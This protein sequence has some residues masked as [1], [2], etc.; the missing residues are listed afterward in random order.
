MWR[1][2]RNGNVS[3]KSEKLQSKKVWSRWNYNSDRSPK[4][5]AKIEGLVQVYCWII[6]HSEI[7]TIIF[8]RNKIG[9][10]VADQVQTDFRKRIKHVQCRIERKLVLALIA[11]Q[12]FTFPSILNHVNNSAIFLIKTLTITKPGWNIYPMFGLY[13]TSE[14]IKGNTIGTPCTPYNIV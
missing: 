3:G 13:C 4:E 6:I 9:I 8:F 5:L 14:I 12:I 10:H 11:F 1:P 7:Q 2:P